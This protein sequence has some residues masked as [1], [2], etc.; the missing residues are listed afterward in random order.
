MP[1]LKGPLPGLVGREVLPELVADGVDCDAVGG[2]EV[3]VTAVTMGVMFRQ[4]P[5]IEGWLEVFNV[6]GGLGKKAYLLPIA[7]LTISF[8]VAKLTWSRS[9]LGMLGL[10]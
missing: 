2:K 1:S 9:S 4:I 6:L 5:I 7:K 3:L 8:K 10:A